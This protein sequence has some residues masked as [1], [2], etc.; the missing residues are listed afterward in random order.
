MAAPK[1]SEE[2]LELLSDEEREGLLEDIDNDDEGADDTEGA[3]AAAA[4]EGEEAAAAAAADATTTAEGAAVTPAVVEPVSGAEAAATPAVAENVTAEAAAAAVTEPDADDDDAS[5]IAPGPGWRA[6]PADNATKLDEIEKQL[7]EITQK[8]DDGDLTGGEYRAQFRKLNDQREDLREERFKTVLAQEAA[9]THWSSVAVPTFFAKHTQY[10][11]PGTI[12]YKALDDEVKKLQATATNPLDPRL[13]EQAH[14]VIDAQIRKSIG[15]ET[16]PTPKPTTPAKPAAKREVVP[17]LAHVPAADIND[18][19][20]DGSK[21]AWLDRLADTDALA[22][23]NA[24]A[25][26]S[27]AER[28][29]YL[30]N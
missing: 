27:E 12:L 15:A 25:K 6:L 20:S 10:S 3:E 4:A 24:L 28:E 26:M 14:K 30:A 9:V 16:P 22:Y 5:D 13:L 11:E 17:S 8:F 23:E 18:A 2:E 21:F 7:D 19:D 1:F 29:Q